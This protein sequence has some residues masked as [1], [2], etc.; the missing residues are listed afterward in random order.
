MIEQLMQRLK[1]ILNFRPYGMDDFIS[2]ANPKDHRDV[3]RLE[4][5]WLKIQNQKFFSS[6]Y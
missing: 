4:E 5:M 1:E 3:Q 2:E 6:N